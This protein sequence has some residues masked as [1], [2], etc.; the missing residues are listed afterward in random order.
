MPLPLA[1]YAVSSER[2]QQVAIPVEAPAPLRIWHL[3]SFDAPTVAVVW[4]LSFAQ[5]ADVHLPLWVPVLVAIGT[6]F[7]YV[8]DRI[9]DAGRAIRSGQFDALRDRHFFHWR[10]RRVLLPLAVLAAMGSVALIFGVMPAITREHDSVLALAALAYFS[11]I[12]A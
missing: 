12:H 6:W 8:G 1:G 9:L 11:G 2:S 10:H 7:V 3:A 4:T 5:A